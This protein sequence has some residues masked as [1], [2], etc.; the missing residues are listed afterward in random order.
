MKFDL[1]IRAGRFISMQD[2]M[3]EVESDR[4][5]G[6]SE[7]KIAA[8]SSWK[9]SFRKSCK[10][11]IDASGMA[12][13]PGFVNGHTHLPM[14][15][16]RGIEDDVPLH[17]W[18]FERMFPLEAKFVDKNFV[19][20]GA[21]LGALECI[22]FGVT[23]VNDMYFYADEIAKALDKAGLRGYVS[24]PFFSNPIPEDKDLGTDKGK[25]FRELTKKYAKHPRIRVAL[26][27]HAPYTCKDEVFN[28]VVALSK[29]FGA[30]IHTH[31]NESKK[32]VEDHRKEHGKGA[33][34]RLAGLGFFTKRTVLAHCVHVDRE[35]QEILAKSGANIVYNPDSNMKLGS[36]VA[37]IPAYLRDGISVAL[38]TDGAAS[39]NDLSLFGAMD[40]GTKLQK[41]ANSDNTAMTAE[42]ALRSATWLGAKALGL[43]DLVGS[44]EV[45]KCADIVMIDLNFP[46]LLPVHNLVSQLVYS[47]QGLEVDTVICDGRILMQ[48]KKILTI[49][50]PDLYRRVEAIR[51]KIAL[52]MRSW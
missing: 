40:I 49:K 9:P 24:Q 11:F 33:V 42:Q 48:G 32:E 28:E 8:I 43:G 44:L 46:H 21:E 38:G 22:R 41:V 16:F 36:G 5:L 31:L 34:E 18:L 25:I 20:M 2:G 47:A 1:G 14:S 26:G 35:E 15:L 51:K 13:L 17:T 29:E 27:P 37:P 7:G 52:E 4:F 23:T 12:V 10:K 19:R 3:V 30:L 45:G 6:V 39:N 50:T